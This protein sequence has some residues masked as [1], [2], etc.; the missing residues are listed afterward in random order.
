VQNALAAIAIAHEMGLGEEVI[1]ATLASFKGVKRRFTKTGT[2]NGITVIDDYGHHPVEIAAVLSA[3][4]QH[5]QGR[6][7][8]ARV[9]A[10]VQPHRYTRLANLFEEFCACFNQADHVVVAPVYAAG[11]P[12]I[13]GVTGEALAQGLR[14]HGHRN[15]RY[16]RDPAEL[17]D[18]VAEIA[19]PGDLVVCLG[20][21]T[22]T[23][24]A[25]ALPGALGERFGMAPEGAK[26]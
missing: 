17:P 7:Q 25:A 9:I 11:E 22:I 1:R 15:V 8:G 5:L 24:W 4:R 10:V 26:A 18:I 19:Q 14:A 12:P 2:V 6:P 13:E 23:Q 20:A 3:A 21:G 16:L